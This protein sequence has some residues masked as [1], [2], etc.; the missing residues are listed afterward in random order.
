MNR[1]SEFEAPEQPEYDLGA[2]TA[3]PDEELED[4][5]VDIELAAVNDL[6]ANIDETME[7]QHVNYS[8][9]QHKWHPHTVKVMK[10]LRTS[11]EDK[12]R[13]GAALS[14]CDGRQCV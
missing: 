12:V 10:V 3:Y 13:R 4:L 6:Q 9:A 11:L 14:P 7:E 8:T 5:N 2:P 1:L